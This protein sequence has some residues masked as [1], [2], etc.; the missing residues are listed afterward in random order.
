MAARQDQTLQIFLI[1]FIFLFLVTAVVAYLGWRGY[2]DAD[3]RATTVQ[4]S[5]ND[6]N[7]QLNNKQAE[8]EELLRMAGFG[9][10]DNAADVKKAA[11]ADMAKFAP[12]VEN[13]S[14]RK[15]LETIYAELQQGAAREADLKVKQKQNEQTLIAVQAEAQKKID[16]YDA[17][18]KKAE[19]RLAAES[20]KFAEDRAAMAKNEEQLQK[21]LADQR[22]KY[23]AQVAERDKSVKDFTEKNQKLEHAVANLIENRKDEPESF[24]VADGRISWVNQNGTVW[25]NLGTSDALRRQVTFSVFDQDLHDASKSKK[26]GSIEVTRLLGEHMAEA[27]ITKDD[28]KNPILTGDNIYSQVWHRGKKLHFALTGIIDIDGDGQSDLQ[29]ARELIELN[30]GVVDAYLDDEG[31]MQGKITAN[32]RYLISGEAPN[33][34]TKV[35]LQT[36]TNDMFK[37]AQSLGVETITLV[38]F[39]SQMGYKPQDRTVHLGAGAK[40]SDFP[41]R[42]EHDSGMGPAARFR[43]RPAAPAATAQ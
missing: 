9:A 25:I 12:G 1:V 20:A 18:R 40:A 16:E 19:E 11:E 3:Q 31:K 22:A 27:R 43:S 35:A 34:P 24:E 29:L 41:A 42:P 33:N 7:T 30:G 2:S 4:N 17:A 21:S 32:T 6:K 36:G 26:K 28:P 5:L 13:P 23:E 14:Y 8:M 15:V 39:L 10:N 38:E 37:E